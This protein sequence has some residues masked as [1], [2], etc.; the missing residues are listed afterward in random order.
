MIDDLRKKIEAIDLEMLALMKE[1]L[2]VVS[3]IGELKIKENLDIIDKKAESSVVKR[4]R[5]FAEENSMDPD[6]AEKI[7]RLLMEESVE[8]QKEM[9]K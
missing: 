5:T 3:L 1:R 8:L 4:F 9:R 7:C 2:D 6:I